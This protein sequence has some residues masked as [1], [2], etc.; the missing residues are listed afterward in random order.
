MQPL[1]QPRKARVL[2]T[3]AVDI[4]NEQDVRLTA[5]K[6]IEY[7]GESLPPKNSPALFVA[8]L[9]KKWNM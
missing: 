9:K 4:P 1:A 6:Q 3:Q 2:A 5:L 8:L 7:F